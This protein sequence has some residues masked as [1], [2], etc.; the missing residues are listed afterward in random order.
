MLSLRRKQDLL[1]LF[2]HRE[3]HSVLG[4]LERSLADEGPWIGN[5][6]LCGDGLVR[7]NEAASRVLSKTMFSLFKGKMELLNTE[8]LCLL[9]CYL[10]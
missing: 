4:K 1:V 3:R 6:E 10:A 9:I 5:P 7:A 8:I 2:V